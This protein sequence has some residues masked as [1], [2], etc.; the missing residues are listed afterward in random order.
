[1]K[2]PEEDDSELTEIIIQPDGRIYAFGLSPEVAA[3]LREM[4][5]APPIAEGTGGAKKGDGTPGV[6]AYNHIGET[7]GEG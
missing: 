6:R 2:I 7:H 4:A 3:V 5:V 1:M